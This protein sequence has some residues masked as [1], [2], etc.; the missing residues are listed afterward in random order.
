[1]P[2]KYKRK[3]KGGGVFNINWSSAVLIGGAPSV[4]TSPNTTVTV[5]VWGV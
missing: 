1:M 3:E 4:R 5:F 2:V